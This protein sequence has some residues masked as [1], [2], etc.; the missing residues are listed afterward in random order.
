MGCTAGPDYQMSANAIVNSTAA[1]AAFASGQDSAFD[2]APMPDHWWLLYDDTRL[3]GFVQE[4][5]KANADLHAADANLRKASFVVREAEAAALPATG[6][7]GSAGLARTPGEIE[8]P[9]GS[10]VYSLG[11]SVSYT[12]DL[13]G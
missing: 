13:A 12:F 10:M 6:I 4:A 1:N 5:L 2:L 3:D 9:P 11:G 7:T 8:H